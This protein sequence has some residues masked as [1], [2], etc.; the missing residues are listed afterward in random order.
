MFG[1]PILVDDDAAIF[2]T[3]WTYDIKALDDCKKAH[4]V[5]D[6]SLR[7]DQDHVLDKTY[8]NYVDQTSS[9]MFYAILA[10]DNLNIY[11]AGVS[12]AFAE[13]PP[14]KQVSIFTPTAHLLNGEYVIGSAL[15]WN[16]ANSSLFSPQCKATLN[17]HASGKSTPTLF[18][19]ILV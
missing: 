16:Q 9:H 3:V 17:H 8:A 6:G 7:A 13:A 15:H 1:T 14:P 5:C 2:H 19:K 12:N 4:M 11:G 18:S 10:A